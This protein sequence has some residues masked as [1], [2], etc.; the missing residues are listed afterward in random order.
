MLVDT[1]MNE[2]PFL[3]IR[4]SWPNRRIDVTAVTQRGKCYYREENRR[5]GGGGWRS[6]AWGTAGAKAR[7]GR[8]RA[9]WV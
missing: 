7:V 1:E 4:H 3:P 2:I 6:W 8:D 9:R 5:V